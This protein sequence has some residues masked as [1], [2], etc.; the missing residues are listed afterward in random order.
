MLD[1]LWGERGGGSFEAVHGRWK[2][3]PYNV[4]L[5]GTHDWSTLCT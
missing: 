3:L 1:R 4:F 2:G 5:D